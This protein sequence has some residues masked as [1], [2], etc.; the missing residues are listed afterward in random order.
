MKNHQPASRPHPSTCPEKPAGRSRKIYVLWGVALTLLLS[1]AL[2]CWLV[3][4]PVWQVHNVLARRSSRIFV[5]ETKIR[6]R[7][8]ISVSELVGHDKRDPKTFDP[9]AELGGPE[10]AARKF[11]IYLMTPGMGSRR[12]EAIHQLS[13]CG[14]SALETLVGLLDDQDAETRRWAVWAIGA[15][16]SDAIGAEEALKVFC[17]DPDMETRL[18]AQQA[19]AKLHEPNVGNSPVWDPLEADTV[20]HAESAKASR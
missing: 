16:G 2:F 20:N 4:V 19:I 10:T 3:V 15:L 18:V 8:G 9:I 5:I 12:K 7:W 11:R 6:G 14:P 13:R 1:T 17:K